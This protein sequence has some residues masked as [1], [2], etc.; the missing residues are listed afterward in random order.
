MRNILIEKEILE[1]LYLSKKLSSTEIGKLF[2][3]TKQAIFY[4]L[5]KYNILRRTGSEVKKGKL[6][7]IKV[8]ARANRFR[9][10]EIENFM[11]GLCGNTTEAEVL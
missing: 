10:S 9:K 2:K 7:P 6:H 11:K 8:G 4:Y 5:K 1:N 3:V